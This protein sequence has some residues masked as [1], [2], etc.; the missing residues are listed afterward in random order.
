[1]EILLVTL[2]TLSVLTLMGGAYLASDMIYLRREMW[3][4]K[5]DMAAERE[6]L[7]ESAQKLSEKS[8]EI[9]LAWKDTNDKLET[10]STKVMAIQTNLHQGLSG[11]S[12]TMGRG[13][14]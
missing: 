2:T 8:H 3:L 10:L 13:L 6:A 14:R 11:P 12:G 5:A 1:M 4:I 7:K 9:G